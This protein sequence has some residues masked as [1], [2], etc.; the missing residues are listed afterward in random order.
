M[1]LRTYH[2]VLLKI[3]VLVFIIGYA[4]YSS[5]WFKCSY[6]YPFDYQPIIYECAAEHDLNPFLVA[7]VIKVE[8]SFDP[9]ACSPKGALGLMQIMPDTGQWVAERLKTPVYLEKNTTNSTILKDPETNIRL[10]TWY[11]DFL[12]QEFSGNEVLYLAAYNGGIGNVRQ[13]MTQYGWT[14]D[15]TDIDQIPFG[16]TRRYVRKVLYYKEQYQEI[17]GQ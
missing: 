4:V 9:D 15:F 12:R 11:L 7:G 5:D 1:K 13:W 14:N 17:Y 2:K 6:I 10:G 16:E 8:S 3:S